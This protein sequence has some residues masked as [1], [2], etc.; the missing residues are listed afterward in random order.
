MV[1]TEAPWSRGGLVDSQAQVAPEWAAGESER[2]ADRA[3]RSSQGTPSGP[4]GE[5][6]GGATPRATLLWPGASHCPQF[7]GVVAP[8]V[9]KRYTCKHAHRSSG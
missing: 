2:G 6:A 7:G 4:R 1:V 3:R 5:E 8:S 9:G